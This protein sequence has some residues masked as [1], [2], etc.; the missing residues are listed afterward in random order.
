M[1]KRVVAYAGAVLVGVAALA[2]GA[3]PIYAPKNTSPP[4]I[5]GT[6]EVDNSITCS[7]GSW[8]RNPT[9]YTLKFEHAD[10]STQIATVSPYLIQSSDIGES[11][12]CRVTA[13]KGTT[14]GVAVSAAVGPVPDPGGDG[15]ANIWMDSDGGT[16]VDNASPVEYAS[17][18][19][20]GS[21]DAVND[22]CDNGDLAYVRT[23]TTYGAQ[24][25][26]GAGGR[27]TSTDCVIEAESGTGRM[28]F[29]GDLLIGSDGSR[30][31]NPV[32]LTIR[33]VQCGADTT[34]FTNEVQLVVFDTDDV[35]IDD[36]ECPAIG[37]YG[38]SD[39]KIDNSDLGPCGSWT[40]PDRSCLTQIAYGEGT[41]CCVTVEDTVIH[42]IWCGTGDA[43]ECGNNHTDG[44]EVTGLN[45]FT[46][47]RV[48]MYRN[49]ITNVR[50][51]QCCGNPDWTGLKIENSQF[52]RPC[53]SDTTAICNVG[54][55][56]DSLNIDTSSPNSW[57]KGTS[58][59]DDGSFT[60]SGGTGCGTGA[61]PFLFVG[62][63]ISINA[64]QCG[65]ANT[66]WTYN[67]FS[68]D[69]GYGGGA[70]SGTG[71]VIGTHPAFVQ[72]SD[73]SALFDLHL[74]GAA[75]LADNIVDTGSCLAT[76]YDVAARG[77]PCDAGADER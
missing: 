24:T 50:F 21:L 70:C 25:I 46:L 65:Y 2:I 5:S 43:S 14:S 44:M 61:S 62:N 51:Q 12:Q 18:T 57:I 28:K 75:A 13:T 20:C 73:T 15:L 30:P 7:N 59:S 42:D 38:I 29:S 37:M 49:D 27:T 60:C 47:R 11:I 39:T 48:K 71:N 68:R 76:D 16:C 36:W 32:H 6:V 26:T 19:A 1:R 9:G 58:F 55:R 72:G 23:G 63:I 3:K 31:N 34:S 22:I 69:T 4:A 54:L 8:T 66:T 64:T 41:E 45:D 33:R 74:T 52:G 77:N 35:L 67:A 10:D 17:A 53:I 56:T 40:S